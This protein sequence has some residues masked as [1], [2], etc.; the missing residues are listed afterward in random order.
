LRLRQGDHVRIEFDA[1]RLGAA[2]GRRDNGAA[3]T[4]T[5]V[6]DIIGGRNL[7]HIQHAIHQA[8]GGRN[9][10]HVFSLLADGGLKGLA[11]CATAPQVRSATTHEA[12]SDRRMKLD[13][14]N[15]PVGF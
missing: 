7:R 5:Q 3:V 12:V 4:R 13:T 6:H 8:L 9:P 1:R 11:C 2:L 14:M 10:D 15:P